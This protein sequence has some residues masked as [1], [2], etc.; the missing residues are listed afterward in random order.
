MI[1][2]LGGVVTFVAEN[3]FDVIVFT[4]SD[5]EAGTEY[6]V[7]L[8]GS[9]SGDSTSGLYDDSAYVPGELVGTVTASL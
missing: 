8:G 3:E 1:D 7:Y 6:E 2:S 5:L 9:V 4:S